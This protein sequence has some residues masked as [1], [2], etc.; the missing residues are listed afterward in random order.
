MLCRNAA[1][2]CYIIHI[3]VFSTNLTNKSSNVY[4]LKSR[5]RG[6]GKEKVEG[7]GKKKEGEGKEV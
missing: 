3:V 4:S 7:K 5:R 2:N 1:L 6:N